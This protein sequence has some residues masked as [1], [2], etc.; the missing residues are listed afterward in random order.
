M[1]R[2]RACLLQTGTRRFCGDRHAFIPVSS[3]AEHPTLESIDRLIREYELKD[4]IAAEWALR[5]VELVQERG[6][7][8]L[9]VEYDGGEP[10]QRFVGE[11]ME[12]G[13]CLRLAVALSSAVAGLLRR[14]LIHRDIN[15]R[16]VIV[17]GKPWKSI[18]RTT[19]V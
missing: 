14:G 17:P 13:P 12:I 18:G 8:M 4:V 16:N 6:R 3:G 10:L 5:P 11:P 15:P 7:T 9:V 19:L 2:R 1:A